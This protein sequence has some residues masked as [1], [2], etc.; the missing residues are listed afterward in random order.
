MFSNSM[1]RR[2]L[3]ASIRRYFPQRKITSSG[4]LNSTNHPISRY[5]IVDDDDVSKMPDDI[6][7]RMNE[8]KEKVLKYIT[9]F[10]NFSS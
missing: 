5:P 1:L 4:L 7:E 3:Q 6:K 2:S 10:F 8:V 9:L